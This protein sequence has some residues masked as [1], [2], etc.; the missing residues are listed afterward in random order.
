[1]KPQ[2]AFQLAGIGTVAAIAAVTILG[3]ASAQDPQ[4]TLRFGH[5]SPPQHPMSSISVPDWVN[6]VEKASNGSIK[7][8]VFPAAQLGAAGRLLRYRPRRR[9]RYFMGQRRSAARPLPGGPG[10]RNA[11]ALFRPAGGDAGVPR[12]VPAI[13]RERDEGRQAVPDARAVPVRNPLQE[14]IQ[15][16]GGLQGRQDAYAELRRSRVTCRCSEAFSSPCRQRR[17]ATRWRRALRRR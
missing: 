8:Q 3:K 16:T 2:R 4:V 14:R 15:I 11:A 10:H 1:M 17:R 6:A 13:R 9:R 7:I 5:W 12:V